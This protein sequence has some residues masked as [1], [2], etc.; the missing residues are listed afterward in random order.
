MIEA[1]L[2]PDHLN[3]VRHLVYEKTGIFF[4]EKKDYYIRNRLAQRM[5]KTRAGTFPEYYGRLADDGE[6]LQCL[7]EA[8]TVNETY[9]FRDFQQLQGFAEK[10]LPRLSA[11]K[12]ARGESVMRGWSAACSTGEEAYTLA[13]ILREMLPQDWNWQIRVDGTD[14]D[15]K[16][17]DFARLG[18]Y[19]ERSMKDTPLAYRERHFHVETGPR[20]RVKESLKSHVTFEQVN[21]VD[22]QAMRTRKGY[23]FIFC[24]N[25]LI[26]FDDESRRRV[27]N[28][29]YDALV[30]GGYLFLGHS[31]SVGRITAAFQLER[32]DDFLCYRK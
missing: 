17:L 18:I 15:R 14:I 4:D 6:E 5:E 11:A 8:M 24:R 28:M 12:R 7:I 13:I 30:P 10:T 3:R 29:L 9:F 31:E 16:V 19:G 2:H 26:Y 23:D 25:A 32:I 1:G 22:R 27:V 20:W 21:F